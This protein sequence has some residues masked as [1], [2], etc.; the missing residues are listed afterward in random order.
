[1]TLCETVRAIEAVAMAQPA[2]HMIVRN[3]VFR[4]NDSPERR[5]GVVAWTQRQ[6]EGGTADDLMRYGFSLF[7]VDRLVED[8]SNG[9]EIQSVGIQTITNM[10]RRLQDYGIYCDSW[11]FESFTQRFADECAGVFC[12]AVLY[13]A[14]N[15]MCAEDFADYNND[16]NDDFLIF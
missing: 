3:D 16:Y 1:M 9:L 2:V 5:Y 10:L 12:N 13:S 6:H 7:Y 14:D 15:G 8:G 11:S 4:L